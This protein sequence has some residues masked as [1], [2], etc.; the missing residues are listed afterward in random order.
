[1]HVC[2]QIFL[3]TYICMCVSGLYASYIFGV[4]LDIDQRMFVIEFC[5]FV[6]M[7]FI[8]VCLC[9]C[10]RFWAYVHIQCMCLYLCEYIYLCEHCSQ[11]LD[12]NQGVFIFESAWCL[13]R[14]GCVNRN[15]SQ[16]H[17]K[18]HISNLTFRCSG[19]LPLSRTLCKNV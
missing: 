12:T 19:Y 1:M 11:I 15:Q 4:K 6:C 16:E 13:F 17:L 2:I 9:M 14:C 10:V 8:V 5:V 7:L 3:Y 18:S